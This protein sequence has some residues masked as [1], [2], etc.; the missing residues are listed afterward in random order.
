MTAVS[1]RA[2]RFFG[3][4]AGSTAWGRAARAP[5][6]VTATDLVAPRAA[7]QYPTATAALPPVVAS[8]R[9]DSPRTAAEAAADRRRAV[10]L[11]PRVHDAVV[12][13][14]RVFD[15]EAASALSHAATKE[16]HMTVVFDRAVRPTGVRSGGGTDESRAARAIGTGTAMAEPGI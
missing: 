15:R 14:H 13:K 3:T 12:R 6:A 1:D 9:A 2:A 8:S 5:R 7:P 4:A 16:K 10:A 11:Q